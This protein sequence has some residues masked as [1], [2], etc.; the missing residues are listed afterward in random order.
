MLWWFGSGGEEEGRRAEGRGVCVVCGVGLEW[1]Q[2]I[3]N[4]IKRTYGG[5]QRYE[6]RKRDEEE[7]G[8]KRRKSGRKR[9][10]TRDEGENR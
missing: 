6:H 1:A 8:Q 10:E 7:E 4:T 3:E 5:D 2:T 9:Q